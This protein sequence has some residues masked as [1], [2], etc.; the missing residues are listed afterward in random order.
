PQDM[1]RLI[2]GV[3]LAWQIAHQPEIARHTHRV[4]LLTEQT[5]GSDSALAAYVRATVSTQFHPCG[6]ARM[7]PPRDAMAVVDQS[8]RLRTIP[9]LR[10]VDASVMPTIP[11]AN[12]NLTCIMIAEHVSDWMRDEA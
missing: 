1:R 6:T 10:V 2:D 8:C 3:R 9:N 5:V 11:R 4:A 12:I 7:G